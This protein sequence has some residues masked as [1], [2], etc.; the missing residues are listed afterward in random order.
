MLKAAGI[1]P[2]RRLNVHGYWKIEEAKMSKSLG[3]VV[4]PLDLADAYG[5]DAFRYFLLREMTFGLDASFSEEALVARLNAD[6]ANDLGNLYSRVL[7]LIERYY[8]GALSDR[9]DGGGLSG[10]TG[11]AVTEIGAAMERFAFS[12]ALGAIWNLVSA[13]NKYLVTNEPWK[14]DPGDTRTKT[15]LFTAAETLRKMA[16]LLMPFLPD[17]AERMLQGLGIDA[18]PTSIGLEEALASEVVGSPRERRVRE[19]RALFPRI[20]TT[21]QKPSR[22]S[23]EV[24]ALPGAPPDQITIEE[25]RRLDLRVAEIV[26][27]EAVPG[28][29]KLVRLRVRL[30][31]E[32]RTIVAGLREQYP[33]ETW[34]GKQVILVANLKPTTLMGIQSQGMVLAAEDEEGKIVLL[35]PEQ[36]IPPGSKIR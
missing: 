4:R 19:V 10:A 15:V 24:P 11:A 26:E 6:L 25:F 1:E 14:Q 20:E 3:K 17:T 35:M 36:P 31:G 33:S 16:V 7:K 30:T 22:R 23:K 29:K 2:Y 8:N 34:P 5:R 32:E 13:T 18:M 9:P 12:E 27:A 28:S 21:S